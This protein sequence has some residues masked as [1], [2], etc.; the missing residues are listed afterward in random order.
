MD[1]S[2]IDIFD[3]LRRLSDDEKERLLICMK[4]AE[5]MILCLGYERWQTVENLNHIDDILNGQASELCDMLKDNSHFE[6]LMKGLILR[7]LHP[8]DCIH[9]FIDYRKEKLPEE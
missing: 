7:I 3:L 8:D 6:S 1:D 4:R 9:D 2:S 5:S